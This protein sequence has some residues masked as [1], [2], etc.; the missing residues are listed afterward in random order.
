MPHGVAALTAY[1]HAPV[2]CHAVLVCGHSAAV[3]RPLVLRSCGT[4]ATDHALA[5]APQL[6]EEARRSQRAE[7]V[8][9]D[10]TFQYTNYIAK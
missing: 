3:S 4:A 6:L 8:H 1:G 7:H 10:A 5:P 9:T 2:L